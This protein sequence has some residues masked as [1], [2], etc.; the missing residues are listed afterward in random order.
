MITSTLDRS[1][2]ASG[3]LAEYE[4]FAD[5]VESLD[6]AQWHAPSRCTGFEVR[7]VAGHV[8]GLAEDA[9]AGVPGSRTAEQEA[10]SLREDTPAQ[11]A[12]RLRAATQVLRDLVAVLD[13]DAWNG[14][15]PVPDLTLG[16]GVLTLWHD[17]YVHADDIRT[18]IGQPSDRGPGLDASVSYLAGELERRDGGPATLMLEGLAPLEVGTDGPVVRGDP[19]QFVLI[20]TGRAD[21]SPLGLDATVNI[22]AG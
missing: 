20:A 3:A 13:D 1:T 9:A 12:A 14:P 21:P 7:D 6:D 16:R 22:Y 18:A 17:T 2:V 11:A 10:A 5:L 19:L 8:I 4:A 15:S